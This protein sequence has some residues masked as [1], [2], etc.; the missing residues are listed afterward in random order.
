MLAIITMAL[1]GLMGP[2]SKV[3]TVWWL[4]EGRIFGFV[5][6][7]NVMWHLKRV[8]SMCNVCMYLCMYKNEYGR[9]IKATK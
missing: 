6:S 8:L 7:Q 3:V 1:S 2:P 5:H 4:R 9:I